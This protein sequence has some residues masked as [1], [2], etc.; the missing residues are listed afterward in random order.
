M[1]NSDR[2]GV[3]LLALGVAGM[4]GF[5]ALKALTSPSRSAGH[6]PAALPAPRRDFLVLYST[7]G[8]SYHFLDGTTDLP[9]GPY[10]TFEEAAADC[11]RF[12]ETSEAIEG[13]AVVFDVRHCVKYNPYP[14]AAAQ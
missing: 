12:D 5:I 9:E 8:S 13:R 3:D 6:R 1:R 4:L 7:H 2:S 10:M 11:Q 14:A